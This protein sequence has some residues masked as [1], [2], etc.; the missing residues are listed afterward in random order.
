MAKSKNSNKATNRRIGRPTNA[1]RAT[2][3]Q[4]A[5]EG[6]VNVASAAFSAGLRQGLGLPSDDTGATVTTIASITGSAIP[7]TAK[8]STAP[9]PAKAS[10]P[11]RVRRASGSVSGRPVDPESKMSKTRTLYLEN[12]KASTP[13]NRAELVAAAAKKFDYSPAT[14]NTYISNI[15]K[16]NGRQLVRR[17]S[18]A[19]K[20]TGTNG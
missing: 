12:L 10:K 17:G 20:R 2:R 6:L 1:E 9:A 19:A 4:S 14:G 7:A 8:V 5:A 15:D 3:A 11:A 16:E 13:L 18:S